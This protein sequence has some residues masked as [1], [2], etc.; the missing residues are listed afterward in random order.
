VFKGIVEMRAA[1]GAPEGSAPVLI[2][3]REEGILKKKLPLK[4]LA[5]F[6]P[7]IRAHTPSL[8][9]LQK[10]FREVGQVWSP[11]TTTYRK[12]LRG[13]FV[14]PAPKPKP[15]RAPVRKRPGQS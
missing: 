3:A 1:D 15:R 7:V 5:S 11:L 12:E 10:R 14:P 9:I 6:S 4:K 13:K 8:P 2:N